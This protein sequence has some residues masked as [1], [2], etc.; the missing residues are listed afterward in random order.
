MLHLGWAGYELIC[1]WNKRTLKNA[2]EA[3]EYGKL[4]PT[5]ADKWALTI[6]KVKDQ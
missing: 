3:A 1:T 5:Q 4:S 6:I 2:M